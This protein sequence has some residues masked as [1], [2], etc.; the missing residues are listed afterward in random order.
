MPGSIQHPLY[1][2]V[3]P[4][5][6]STK[7]INNATFNQTVTGADIDVSSYR[8]FVVTYKT[9]TATNSPTMVISLQNKDG[10]NNYIIDSDYVSSTIT[11]A[12]SG[13]GF[14][15]FLEAY[16]TIRIVCT[17][18]GTGSFATTTVELQLKA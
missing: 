12:T 11:T 8:D 16:G 6:T 15:G 13:V 10:N 7:I 17:Y 1:T 14:K 2:I 3:Y 18:G 4:I 5:H 9:G